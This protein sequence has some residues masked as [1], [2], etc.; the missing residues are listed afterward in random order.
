MSGPVGDEVLQRLR[1]QQPRYAEEGYLFVLSALHHT[2]E[3]LQEPRHIA[4]RELVTGVRDLAIGKFGP[5]AR[6]VLGH[7]GIHSTEDIGAI[8]FALVEC[9]VLIKQP[10]DSPADFQDVFDFEEEF[11][12]NY[13]WAGGRFS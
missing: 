6:S 5:M 8:V 1:A 13:P 10:T 11:E 3:T 2:L 9:G 7:W 12:R 4:G